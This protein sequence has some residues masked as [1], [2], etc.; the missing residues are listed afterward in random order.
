M[1]LIQNLRQKVHNHFLAK[2][3][4]SHRA[5]RQSVDF[6]RA[7]TV[8][9]LFNATNLNDR[10]KV[11]KHARLLEQKGKQVKLLGFVNTKKGIENLPFSNFS[12]K[13]MD[14]ATRP[15]SAEVLDFMQRDFDVLINISLQEV[16][17]LEYITTL[18]KAKFR[19]GPYTE[20]TACYELMLDVSR[21]NDID[22][23]MHQAMF[24]LDKMNKNVQV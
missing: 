10:E 14:W 21:S 2:A 20:Q 18:S 19:V 3:L 7:K 8:G 11:L 6:D 12:R 5:Q 16:M 13:E 24:F 4:K 17:P 22:A 23:F 1:Q 15:T 9:I